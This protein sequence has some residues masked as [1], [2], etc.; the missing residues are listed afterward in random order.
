MLTCSLYILF[1]NFEN[2]K[3]KIINL[4]INLAIEFNTSNKVNKKF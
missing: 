4:L 2:F 1:L 3:D